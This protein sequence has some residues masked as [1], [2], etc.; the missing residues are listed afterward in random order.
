M[1][2]DQVQAVGDCKNNNSMQRSV[3]YSGKADL[4]RMFSIQASLPN[5]QLNLDI[6]E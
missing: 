1:Q 3:K 5:S 4:E 2:I 6:R